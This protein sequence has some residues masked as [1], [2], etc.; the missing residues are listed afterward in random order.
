M[1]ARPLCAAT[2]ITAILA[3]IPHRS[4]FLLVDRIKARRAATHFIGIKCVTVNEPFFPGHFPEIRSCPAC[5]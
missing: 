2:R 5:F 1:T 3:R 4:P